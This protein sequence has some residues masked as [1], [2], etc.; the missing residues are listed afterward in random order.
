MVEQ[1]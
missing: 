1:N